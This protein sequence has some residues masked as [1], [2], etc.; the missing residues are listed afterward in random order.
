MGAHRA[1]PRSIGWTAL[2][3]LALVA[4]ACSSGSD[5]ARPSRSAPR[6]ASTSSSVSSPS[7]SA[8]SSVPVKPAVCNGDDEVG[9]DDDGAA[10]ALLEVP[11]LRPG[12]WSYARTPPCPWALSGD[13]L[14]AVP[15]CRAAAAAG[16]GPADGRPRNGNARST[17]ARA[18][19]VQLDDRIEIYTSRQNVDAI[20]A[21][22]RQPSMSACYTAA[23]RARA[24]SEP[25]TTVRDVEVIAFT[26][27]PGPAELRLGFPAVAGYAADAGF[28]VGTAI[29]FTSTTKGSS[30]RVAMLVVTFGS[31]GIMSTLTLI[32][33]TPTALDD[34]DLPAILK[35]AAANH[36]S[37]F[38]AP[39]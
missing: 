12:D 10:Q 7:A 34:V 30:K 4:S 20:R 9:Q 1:T 38:S 14:L 31:G 35:A 21:M 19:G 8:T 29:T 28:A 6:S 24:A 3:L 36:R 11:Q 37:I 33:P 16:H 18:D 39:G 17:F 26:V 5:N 22:L 25:A 32:G 27:R 23:I 13:E 15:E 2:V